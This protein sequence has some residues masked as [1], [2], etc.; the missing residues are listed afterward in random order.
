MGNA[1]ADF[2]QPAVADHGSPITTVAADQAARC[3]PGSSNSAPNR[4]VIAATRFLAANAAICN[5][6]S[7]WFRLILFNKAG[8]RQCWLFQPP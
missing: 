5:I 7:V 4:L 3:N 2:Q 1:I 6:S 8:G